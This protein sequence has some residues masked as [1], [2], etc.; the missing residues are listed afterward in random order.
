MLKRLLIGLVTFSAIAS[1]SAV[2]DNQAKIDSTVEKLESQR[3]IDIGGTVRA[4]Y[5]KSNIDIDQDVDAYNHMPDR[6]MNEFVQLDL[7]MHFRPWDFVRANLLMRMGA[8]MQ[9]YFANSATMVNV[10]WANVEGE[11]GKNFHWV[12]GDFRQQYS[13]LTLY[14]PGVDIMYEPMI[15]ARNREMG[16]REALI[17]GNQRN[18]QGV[19]LQFRKDMGATFG[20]L[21]TEGMLVRLRRAERLDTTGAMGNLLPGEN[22][23]GAT[24]TGTFDKYAAIANFELFP[25]NKNLMVGATYIYTWDDEKSKTYTYYKNDL[26]TG[27]EPEHMFKRMPVNF[28]DSLPQDTKVGAV[29]LGADVAGLL[30]NKNLILDVTG[31]FAYSMDKVYEEKTT[32]VDSLQIAY[33][34]W[35]SVVT[36]E[37]GAPVMEPSSLLRDER[38]NIFDTLKTLSS[39]N[40]TDKG[41]AV[42]ANLNAGFRTSSWMV[43]VGIDYVHNDSA[44]F[45]S[46]AQSPSFVARRVMNSDKDGDLTKYGPYAP[47]YSTFDALYFFTPKHSPASK[48]LANDDEAMKNGQTRSYNIA[49]YAKT[50]YTTATMT[51]KELA[52]IDELS[53]ASIQM[54]L[55]FGLATSN[56][57]GFRANLVAGLGENNVVEV[58]GLFTKMEQVKGLGNLDKASFVEYGGGGKIDILALLGIK[59]PLELS[60]SYKHAERSISDAEF[61]TDFINVGLYARYWKRLGVSVGAQR[62]DAELNADGALLQQAM[63]SNLNVAVAPIMKGKQIQWMVGLDYTLA[64]HAWLA[65]NYGQAS[66]SNSYAVDGL[67]GGNYNAVKNTFV[68]DTETNLPDYMAIA[69]RESTAQRLRHKFVRS[70]VQASV[71]VEF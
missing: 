53:D 54:A 27:A 46:L 60:G 55:P 41:M 31:E 58:Q 18:L 68:A 19:N 47:L 30:G 44:W 48:T 37:D 5:N 9:D 8:G 22:I 64:P 65:L 1:A 12:V 61:K 69:S 33:D 39:D 26:Y 6:E 23:A 13:P 29:R 25:L 62:I 14:M 56:R 45:N 51:R 4:V 57:N 32:Y 17:Q 10:Q 70:I 34:Q 36:G 71:N 50:S 28:K 7:D 67:L 38:G 52:L 21:R 59:L 49:P 42:T 16:E 3:G 35:G 43:N 66:V 40:K 20:E 15:F 63:M 24:Q 11:I 2:A